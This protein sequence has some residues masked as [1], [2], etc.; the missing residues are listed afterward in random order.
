MTYYLSLGANLG[1]REKTL[2]E[3]IQLI[4]EQ[5]GLVPCCSSFYY[6]EPWGF[7]SAN[8]FCNVCCR[9]E[10]ALAP[11]DVLRATQDIERTLGRSHKTVHARYSDR[12]IDI[13]L[14]QA[15]EGEKEIVWNDSVLTLPHPLW[16]Q[17]EFVKVPLREITT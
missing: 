14:I 16:Q 3:A 2:R 10:T 7:H 6:S 15:F 11:L 13:D 4:E 1:N 8:S 12:T 5:I 17:R 9:L